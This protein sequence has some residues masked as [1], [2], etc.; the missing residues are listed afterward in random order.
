M[1]M[2]PIMFFMF[3]SRRAG[4]YFDP[5]PRCKYCGRILPKQRSFWKWLNNSESGITCS[6]FG[7]LIPTFYAMLT[8]IGW[9]TCGH[10]GGDDLTDRRDTL[11]RYTLDQ[12][13]W[14]WQILH[15]LW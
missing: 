8:V 9:I 1:G 5:R 13:H 14:I 10:F 15:Q 3:R 12:W 7:V 6:V 4:G 2:F 11:L